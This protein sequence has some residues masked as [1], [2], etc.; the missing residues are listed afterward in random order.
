MKY[1]KNFENINKNVEIG[2]YVLLNNSNIMPLTITRGGIWS[3]GLADIFKLYITQMPGQIEKINNYPMLSNN[4]KK[5]YIIRY[6]NIPDIIKDF[7]KNN[8]REFS[9]EEIEKW[10]KNKKE[11]SLHLDI[12]RYNL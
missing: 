10:F 2:D 1:L 8:R 5:G 3:K 9:E 11:L 6:D 4:Y 7:F 12:D